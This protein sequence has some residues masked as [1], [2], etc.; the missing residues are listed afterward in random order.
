MAESEW[1]KEIEK[2]A[3]VLIIFLGFALTTWEEIQQ[4]FLEIL[5]IVVTY[6]T[7]CAEKDA[8]VL[9]INLISNN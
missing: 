3:I 9:I 5:F 2:D 4:F 1:G 8:I 6:I 7:L